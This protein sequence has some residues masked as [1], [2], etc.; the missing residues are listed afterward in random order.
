MGW[1]G[2]IAG[3][4]KTY[5]SNG[6]SGVSPPPRKYGEGESGKQKG[7][8]MTTIA[9]I[10]LGNMGGPMAAN[11]V[12]AGHQVLGV[13]LVAE[14]ARAAARPRAS[15]IADSAVERGSR[16]RRR[17][18][19]VA[20]GQACARRMERDRRRG[21]ARRAVD[22]F[23]DHRRR[24]RAQGA[25]L[26]EAEGALSIDAPVSGGVG[27]AK[28]AT[29]TFMCGGVGRAS[30]PRSRSSKRWASASS[31]AARAGAGR[32]RKSATT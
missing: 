18:H 11:L 19:D 13:D 15:T 10:G 22:R 1:G 2:G 30:P 7:V 14:L 23:L 4:S 8:S 9:F 17:R 25:R 28:G 31:I 21:E 12:K 24:E 5:S 16:G 6:Y 3:R 29:L 32:P 27:G 20:G 26:A